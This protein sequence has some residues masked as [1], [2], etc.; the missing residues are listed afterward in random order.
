M[1][2]Y[3]AKTGN[4]NRAFN[5]SDKEVLSAAMVQ[6]AIYKLGAHHFFILKTLK[7]W[8]TR[9]SIPSWH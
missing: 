6:M 3:L 2:G 8:H 9:S 1:Y 5:A 4:I 7:S